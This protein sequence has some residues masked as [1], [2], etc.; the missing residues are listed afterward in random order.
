M[1]GQTGSILKLWL[2]VWGVLAVIALAAPGLVA[3]ATIG[4]LTPKASPFN[5][6]ETAHLLI[7]TVHANR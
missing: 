3:A 1:S 6:R 7:W 4:S 2:I 5:S